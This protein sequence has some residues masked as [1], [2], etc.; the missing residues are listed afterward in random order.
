M[1]SFSIILPAWEWVLS[2]SGSQSS[3]ILSQRS[4]AVVPV[5]DSAGNNKCSASTDPRIFPI[6]VIAWWISSMTKN[7]RIQWTFAFLWFL[8]CFSLGIWT[9]AL[10]WGRRGADGVK[11]GQKIGF[12]SEVHYFSVSGPQDLEMHHSNLSSVL[13]GALNSLLQKV[14]KEMV[15][16]GAPWPFQNDVFRRSSTPSPASLI[17]FFQCACQFLSVSLFF[18]KSILIRSWKRKY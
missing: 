9:S 2:W 14:D 5:N 3:L 11:G 18:F 15:S 7:P 6:S 12:W 10:I 13:W 4:T 8:T 17:F 1:C 16:D